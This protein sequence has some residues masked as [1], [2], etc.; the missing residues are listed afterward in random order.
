MLVS[1]LDVDDV[2]ARLCRAVGH[3]AC[4]ILHILTVDIHL[5][6]ALDGQ[7]ETPVALEGQSSLILSWH[8]HVSD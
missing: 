2:V 6:G 3:L 1:K 8:D 4:S 7:T 5:A